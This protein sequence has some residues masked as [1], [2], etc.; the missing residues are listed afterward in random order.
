MI[1][2][3]IEYIIIFLFFWITIVSYLRFNINR[4]LKIKGDVFFSNINIIK[5]RKT[6][7]F[8]NIIYANVDGEKIKIIGVSDNALKSINNFNKISV[9]TCMCVY[10]F[11][12]LHKGFIFYHFKQ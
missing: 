12:L 2:L 5:V 6:F 9:C 11:L 1:I 8:K 4:E 10:G 7:L 3:I